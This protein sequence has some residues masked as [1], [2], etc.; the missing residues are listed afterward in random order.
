MSEILYQEALDMRI[1][2][3]QELDL[4]FQIG[5]DHLLLLMPMD[6]EHSHDTS[7]VPESSKRRIRRSNFHS[8]RVHKCFHAVL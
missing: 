6:K 1:V 7:P 4:E 8:Q 2:Y 3:K 5:A